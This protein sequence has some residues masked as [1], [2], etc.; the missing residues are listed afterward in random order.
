MR[1]TVFRLSP[2]ALAL[3]TLHAGTTLASEDTA[4]DAVVVTAPAM[5]SPLTVSTDPK[6]PRQPMPAHDGADLLKNIPGFSV[7][8]KG[9]TDGDPVF[10]GMAASRLG[11]LLDGEMIL[12][13]CGMR[14]DPP[15]AYVFPEAYDRVIVQKGPQTVLYGPGNSAGVVRFERTP[16][17]F[18]STGSRFDGSLLVGSNDRNDQVVTAATGT[19]QFYAD[20]AA[21]R[22]D[23]NNYEDGSG[24][25]IHSAYT[26]WST[27]LALGWTPDA[28][29]RIELSLAKS[30]GEAAYADR[31]MDGVKFDRENV[32]LKFEKRMISPWL[33]K[34]E[35]QLYRNYVDHVMDNYSL[36]TATG[37]KMVSNP[38]RE[39]TGGRI[40]ATLNV[41]PS[42]VLDLG[43]D[44]QKNEHSLRSASSMMSDPDYESLDRKPDMRFE[45]LGIFAELAHEL[46]DTDRVIGGLR[47]DRSTAEDQ[48]TGKTSS[49]TKETDDLAAAFLRWERALGGGKT[50][51][52]GIGHS[53]RAADYWERTKN[54]AATSPMMTGAASTFS[55]A[56]EKTTQLDLGA[57]HRAGP[58]QAS[59]SLFY[60]KHR[61]YILIEQLPLVSSF[62]STARNIDATTYGLESDMSY[63]LAPRW[64][65]T[66]TLAWVHGKNDTDGTPLAQIPPLE[67][68]LGLEYDTGVWSAGALWRLVGGQHRVDVGAGNIV[69]QDIGPTAGFGVFSINA[70]YRVRKD[71]LVSAGIDNL[72]DK[73]YAEHISRSGAMINGYEQTTRVNEPGRTFWLKARLAL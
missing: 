57:I 40:A 35:A 70:G 6:A 43:I 58:L 26:R 36:R 11:I 73:T 68:R 2:L 49:G 3:S 44:F 19:P 61:D 66:A 54:P 52:A 37:M 33:A 51:Y 48:R 27:N 64:T 20:A 63:R 50:L 22:S 56:P 39:T 46:D 65:G 47:L 15:T 12:G 1:I 23:A 4:L 32:G 41:A 30:D 72:F 17:R 45:T 31:S 21:T 25:E 10:R 16:P 60:A 59:V 38:D 18:D 71:V 42:S 7:I 69:G 67:G 55:L 24:R 53:E 5:E 34:L 13:G 29:T 62:A 14:M 28:N 8:R 9:G